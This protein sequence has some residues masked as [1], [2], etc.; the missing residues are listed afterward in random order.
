MSR[1]DQSLG[2]GMNDFFI[3]AVD[4]SDGTYDYYGFL[5]NDG[6]TLIMRT[7]KTN[8]AYRYW[9]GTG[10]FSTNWAAKGTVPYFYPSQ[11]KDP[12]VS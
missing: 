4:T 8:T 9:V 1:K 3:V 2:R 6:V 10:N 5:D 7:N 12:T 11:L